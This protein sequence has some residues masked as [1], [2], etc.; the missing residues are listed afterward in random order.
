MCATETI[1]NVRISC[2]PSDSQL[3]AAPCS[4]EAVSP[5]SPSA[6]PPALKSQ[7]QGARGETQQPA[8][9]K[10]QTPHNDIVALQAELKHAR[11]ALKQLVIPSLPLSLPLQIIQSLLSSHPSLSRERARSV[12]QI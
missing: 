6:P 8:K 3:T 5:D 4:F 2:L 7:L 12:G 9:E 11:E 10:A 1:W